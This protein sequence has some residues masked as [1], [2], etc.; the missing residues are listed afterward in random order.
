M[1]HRQIGSY[2]LGEGRAGGKMTCPHKTAYNKNS[3]IS[4]F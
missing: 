2:L 4:K 3:V 1:G